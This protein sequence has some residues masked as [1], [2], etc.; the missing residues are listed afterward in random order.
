MPIIASNVAGHIPG[1]RLIHMRGVRG[2]MM[3]LNEIALKAQ[4]LL[5]MGGGQVELLVSIT[6]PGLGPKTPGGGYVRDGVLLESL[7][8][9]PDEYD[10]IDFADGS[11]NEHAIGKI[12][13]ASF[14]M[15]RIKR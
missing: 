8:F 15:R 4:E 12:R 2:T 6:L 14:I 13:S 1:T 7:I 9:D 5:M 3:T 10:G 11:A